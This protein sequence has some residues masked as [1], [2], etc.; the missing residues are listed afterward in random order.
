MLDTILITTGLVALFGAIEIGYGLHRRPGM[1]TMR[2]LGTSLVSLGVSF[3]TRVAL[4]VTVLLPLGRLWPGSKGALAG[5]AA[6][7]FAV[8]YV[9]LV[10]YGFYWVHRKCHEVPWL[11]RLHK[12]HHVSEQLHAAVTYR[13]NWI[14]NLLLP[15]A[16]VAP[17]MVWLGQPGAYLVGTAFYT[18]IALSLHCDLRWDLHLQRNRFLRPFMW[19]IE[20]VITLPDVH[21]VHHGLGRYGNAMKNYGASLAIFDLLHGTLVI[22]HARQEGFGLPK[23]AS[24]EPWT[25]QIFWPLVRS[26]KKES[27]TEEL[28]SDGQTPTASAL[29]MAKAVIYTAEGR[30]IIVN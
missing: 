23:G 25:E 5:H 27:V 9:L 29:A 8:L 20:R 21:H 18:L 26:K 19:V 6:W 28:S 16:W 22:P 15:H 11:W 1:L 4:N 7:P 3:L 17:L 30:T 14:F 2:E 10:D 12:P 13:E 24:I